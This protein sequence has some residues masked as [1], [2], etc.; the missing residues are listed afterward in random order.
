MALKKLSSYNHLIHAE[1]ILQ[2]LGNIKICETCKKRMKW[3][4]GEAAT[5]RTITYY[6]I[7][8]DGKW[9]RIF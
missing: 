6:S 5:Q 2:Y 1:G 8:T 4:F 9:Q 7:Y 3:H